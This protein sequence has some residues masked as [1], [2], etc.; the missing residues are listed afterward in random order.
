M[1]RLARAGVLGLLTLICLSGCTAE[2][3]DAPAPTTAERAGSGA[4]D[5]ASKD[6]GNSTA[7]LRDTAVHAAER[8]AVA[9]MS[10]D[11]RDPAAKYDRLLALLSG[12]ARQEWEQQRAERL[13]EIT[14]DAVT[15]ERATVTA[16]G[17]AALDPDTPAATVLAAG[18]AEVS[19]KAAPTAQERRYRLR[20]SLTRTAGEWTVSE[21]RFVR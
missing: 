9:V 12:P 19:S 7:K 6:A 17:V 18:T 11:H 4:R 21:L 14:S 8:T 20:M 1:T 10:L 5:G 15:V 2:G 13:A 16:S 3:E